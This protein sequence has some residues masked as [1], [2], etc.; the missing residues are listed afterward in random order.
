MFRIKRCKLINV[1]VSIGYRHINSRTACIDNYNGVFG[2]I[3]FG[4]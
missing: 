3:G 2:T 4:F 1:N